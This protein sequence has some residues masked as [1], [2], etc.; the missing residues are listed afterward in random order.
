VVVEE[1]KGESNSGSK[2]GS[3]NGSSGQPQDTTMS[4]AQDEDDDY[5]QDSTFSSGL[6]KTILQQYCQN[7]D[8]VED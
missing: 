1:I 2:T 8:A 5:V 3:G 4:L 6:I 7:E